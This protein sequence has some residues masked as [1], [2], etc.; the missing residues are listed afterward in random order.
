MSK[1][2]LEA[3]DLEIFKRLLRILGGYAKEAPAQGIDRLFNQVVEHGK[4]V[5]P[6][7]KQALAI[8]DELLDEERPAD[9]V[10]KL[11]NMRFSTLPV[12]CRPIVKKG[13]RHEVAFWNRG[14]YT[15][16]RVKDLIDFDGAGK[17][18][19]WSAVDGTAVQLVDMSKKEDK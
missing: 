14:E 9:T 19:K 18:G 11:M 5:M 4:K 3:K 17:A 6:K 16:D 7:D 15:S 1:K 10:Q 13:R 8:L 2:I 12:C